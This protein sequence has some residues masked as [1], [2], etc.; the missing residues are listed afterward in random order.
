[1]RADGPLTLLSQGEWAMTPGERAAVDGVLRL[2]QPSLS[3]EIGTSSGGSL[4]AI[5]LESREVHS[6]DLQR[7]SSLTSERF[8]NVVFHTGDSHELLPAFLEEL[9]ASDR[10]VDFALVDGDHSA[11]GVQRDVQDLLSSRSVGPSVIL[12]HDTLNRRVR[13]GLEGVDYGAFD[14]VR[15]VDLDF[16]PGRVMCEG[17]L[18]DEYW[19][20]LG[21]IV[22]GVG[23]DIPLPPSAYPVS[24]V[25]EGFSKSLVDSGE[26][27]EPLGAGQLVELEQELATQKDLVRLMES[28]GSWRLTAP[29]RAA[30]R[31]ARRAR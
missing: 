28:S 16:V 12:L 24:E 5:S 30:K 11:Q 4:E 8:P 1:M 19:S 26:S 3:I 22:M 29:L 17:P 15:F 10:N 23:L 2:L 18:K 21:I 6:F 7:H 27:S 9:S 25:Y 20:G 13:T 31:V 14:K